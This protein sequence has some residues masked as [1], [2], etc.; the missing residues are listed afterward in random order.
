MLTGTEYAR[1]QIALKKH[2]KGFIPIGSRREFAI[3]TALDAA[4]ELGQLM[5]YAG[6]PQASEDE[7]SLWF[8]ERMKQLG[9][10]PEEEPEPEL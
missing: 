10:P 5:T 2:L 1:L 9:V 6:R 4:L 7:L 8:E 3:W